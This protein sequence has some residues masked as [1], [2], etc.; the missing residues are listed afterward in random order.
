MGGC[1]VW[2]PHEELWKASPPQQN[3][4]G[5]S[6]QLRIQSKGFPLMGEKDG[7]G[8]MEGCQAS[9]RN[10]V[11]TEAGEKREVRDEGERMLRRSKVL[12]G[13]REKA[14]KP[15]IRN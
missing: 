6:T 4:P 10:G 2:P 11:Q 9:G 15:E 13:A 14:V 3:Q 1:V 7:L 5:L 12:N 8:Q